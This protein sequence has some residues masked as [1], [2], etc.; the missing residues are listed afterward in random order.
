MQVANLF[1]YGVTDLCREFRWGQCCE[2]YRLVPQRR[3]RPS[4]IRRRLG[5]VGPAGF[6][7]DL[8]N[9]S[10]RA[11]PSGREQAL[12]LDGAGRVGIAQRHQPKQFTLQG[13]APTIDQ[14]QR[15]RTVRP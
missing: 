1:V 3:M 2:A 12:Q 6:I 5:I 13:S 14:R 9:E 4:P 15:P 8:A 10:K 11:G 7:N